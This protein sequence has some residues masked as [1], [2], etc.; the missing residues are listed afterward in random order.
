MKKSFLF[1]ILL[2]IST[3]VYSQITFQKT[4][5]GSGH[6]VGISLIEI[7]DGGYIIGGYTTSFGAG[8]TDNYI[9][10]TDEYGDTIWTKTFGSPWNDFGSSTILN[11]NN[12]YIICGTICV[13]SSDNSDFLLMSL[14]ENGDTLWTRL[15]GG[16]YNELEPSIIETSD[17]GYLISGHDH[18]WDMLLIRT[19]ISGDTLW[20]CHKENFSVLEPKQ[21]ILTYDN[22][23][24]TL[25]H[26]YNN[27]AY[28]IKTDD[29]GNTIWEDWILIN[30]IPFMGNS[31]TRAFGNGYIIGGKYTDMGPDPIYF[32]VLVKINEEGSI[33]WY[34][35]YD[36]FQSYN[37]HPSS[38]QMTSDSG[39]IFAS[40]SENLLLI[41]TNIDGVKQ[42]SQYFP[43]YIG[44]QVLQTNDLGYA[45]VGYTPTVM[46]YV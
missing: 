16:P 27:A 42:W 20:T 36:D 28:G 1:L 34:K 31:I 24:L 19:T 29:F 35:I 38:V 33:N 4:Y 8:G 39:F 25:A 40:N 37:I 7:P 46:M 44:C 30:S 18:S 13:D 11:Q 2:S 6:D 43:A 10:K 15:Y 32:P 21:S 45:I 22:S 5:G 9:I 12:E 23:Y 3:L 17:G 26:T 41:K 14:N